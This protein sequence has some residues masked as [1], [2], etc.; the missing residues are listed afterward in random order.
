[1]I[2]RAVCVGSIVAPGRY[3]HI[4][5]MAFTGRLLFAELR[6][7]SYNS[8]RLAQ[9]EDALREFGWTPLPFLVSTA[10]ANRRARNER[11]HDA[12]HPRAAE[13]ADIVGDLLRFAQ[14][15]AQS[16]VLVIGDSTTAFCYDRKFDARPG[17]LARVV[18]ANAG[19]IPF[20]Q[21]VSGSHFGSYNGSFLQQTDLSAQRQWRYDAVLLIGGWNEEWHSAFDQHYLDTNVAILTARAVELLA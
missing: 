5:A 12:D 21:A 20:F 13:A 7:H 18:E 11:W 6:G 10:F 14:L 4:N 8:S 16:S 3:Q 1:M 2:C 17:E 9:I 19:V 15:P